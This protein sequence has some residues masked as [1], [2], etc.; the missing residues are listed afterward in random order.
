VAQQIETPGN[1]SLLLLSHALSQPKTWLLTHPEYNLSTDEFNTL[2]KALNQLLQGVPLPHILGEWEFYG[3]SFIVSPN[4]LIPRPE[5]ERLVERAMELANAHSH[6]L[7]ADVGTGSG[8][9]AVSLAASLPQA[10]LV[11]TD[12]SLPALA[13]AR[14]NAIRHAQPSIHFLQADLLKAIATP[15]DLICA[16][17]PYIPTA[18]VDGLEVTRWEPKLALDGGVTGLDLIKRLLHQAQTRLAPEGTLLLE[19]ESTLGPESLDLAK[20]FFSGAEIHLHQ[21]L[22]KKDRLVEVH[23]A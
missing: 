1:V 23:L 14:R 8:A 22:A 17:L 20:S 2:Q 12:I 19:I 6:P 7:I 21:D 10:T 4:V 18:T 5:T 9:I 11:A 16:N 13:I 3:R 15:F